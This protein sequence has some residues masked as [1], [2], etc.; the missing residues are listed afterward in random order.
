VRR[1]FVPV[2][3]YAAEALRRIRPGDGPLPDV[4]ARELGRLTGDP[5]PPGSWRW[6]RVPPHLRM[7]FLVEDEAGR[8]LAAGRDL[9]TLQDELAER[10]EAG[11]AVAASTFERDGLRSWTIGTLPRQVD[12]T[13]AGFRRRAY[14]ALVDRGDSVAVRVLATPAEQER[15]MWAGTRRLLLLMLPNPTRA[16]ER[17]L[18]NDTQLALARSPYPKVSDLFDDC[19]ECAV[20]QLLGDLGGPVWTETAFNALRIGVSHAL[21]ESVVYVVTVVAGILAIANG[22]ELRLAGLRAPSLAPSLTDVERHLHR[23]VRPGFIAATGVARLPDLMRYLEGIERRLDKLP[24]GA[25]RDFDNLR[26]VQRLERRYGEL[27]GALGP[28]AADEDVEAI[29]WMIEELR[30]SYFAQGLG[31]AQPVSEKRILREIDRWWSEA[32]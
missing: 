3:D 7:R 22:I 14:P 32:V 6:D 16:A 8:E 2:P 28:E 10:A 24:T 9:R 25:D 17:R 21:T 4:L 26:R 12:V 20:D 1:S 13:W 23:L 11:L 27:L 30:I 5:V 18:S 15:A 31:T 19:V 29:G